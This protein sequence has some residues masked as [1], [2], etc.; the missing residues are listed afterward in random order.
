MLYTLCLN[1]TVSLT[2]KKTKKNKEKLMILVLLDPSS[3]F[4]K[5]ASFFVSLKAV[6]TPFVVCK[7]LYP[8]MTHRFYKLKI[9]SLF[10][11]AQKYN[12]NTPKKKK[13]SFVYM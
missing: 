3:E 12:P 7:V 5:V 10:H 11:D 2:K 4:L 9:H 6:M 1:E 13:R 8:A